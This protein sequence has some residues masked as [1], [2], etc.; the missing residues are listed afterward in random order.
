[1]HLLLRTTAWVTQRF[2]LRAKCG[3]SAVKLPLY[4]GVLFL[5]IECIMLLTGAAGSAAA[6]TASDKA[7]AEVLFDEGIR[8]LKAGDTAAACP[9]FE[10]SQKVDPGIGTL[11][12]LGECYRREGRTASAWGTFREAASLADAAGDS[13]RAAAGRSRAEKLEKQLS[14]LSFIIDSENLKIEEF[15]LKQGESMVNAAF[16]DSSI[17]VDPGE[18]ALVASAPGYQDYALTVEVAEGPSL[19]EAVIPALVLK[20]EVK[21]DVTMP[22]EPEE[23]QLKRS[24][25]GQRLVGLVVGG[26]GLAGLATGTIFGVLALNKNKKADEKCNGN[27]CPVADGGFKFSQDARSYATISTV[28]FIAGG[29]LA[30]TGATLY[31][32]APKNKESSSVSLTPD[33]G[34]ARLQFTRSF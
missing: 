23:K 14:R 25:N 32:L 20:S 16:F 19:S 24:G 22:K 18:I 11:L 26:V 9:K 17:P 2:S 12:Y 31:F 6:Q 3:F 15:H 4:A 13:D 1:M 28:G 5:S 8:L 33:Y 10:G 34:G 27:T 7:A 29:V 21:I 30:A